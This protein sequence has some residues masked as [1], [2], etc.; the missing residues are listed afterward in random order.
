MVVVVAAA[1]D[2]GFATERRATFKRFDD[3]V[4][5]AR[6]TTIDEDEVE[7]AKRPCSVMVVALH[8]AALRRS[9]DEEVMSERRRR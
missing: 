7:A 9:L 6:F 5:A 4:G 2:V 3:E 1:V 8:N